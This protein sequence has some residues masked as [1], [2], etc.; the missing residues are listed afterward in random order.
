MTTIGKLNVKH[1]F[2]VNPKLRNSMVLA[3]D[4]ILAYVCGHQTVVMNT[5]SREQS[6]IPGATQP[7]VSLG[8][9][10]LAASIS[11]KFIAVADKAEP[12]AAVT[13]YDSQTLRRKKVLH[14]NELGSREIKCVAFSEDGKLCLTQGA[15]PEWNLVLWNVEKTPKVMGSVKISMS[16]ETPVHQVS[17]C[18]WDPSVIVVFGKSIARLFRYTDGQLRPAS[19]SLRRDHANFISHMWLGEDKLIIGTEMGEILLV[20][21]LEFRAVVYPTGAESEEVTPIL[22]FAPTSRGFVCGTTGGEIRYFDRQDDV[23]EHYQMVEPSFHLPRDKERGALHHPIDKGNIIALAMGADDA[24]I[25]QTDSQQIYQFA[26]NHGGAGGKENSFSFLVSSFHGP[27]AKGESAITGIDCALWRPIAATCGKDCTVRVWNLADRKIEIMKEFEDEPTALSVHP[28]GLYIVVGFTERIR[29]LAVLLDDLHTCKDFPVRHCTYVKFARGGQYFAAVSGSNIYL[30]NTYTGAQIGIMR[31]H[32]GRPR[33]LIFSNYDSKLLSIGAEGNVFVWDVMACTRRPEQYAGITPFQAGAALLDGSKAFAATS[34]RIIREV[35]FQKAAAT[36]P[37]AAAAEAKSD[38]AIPAGGGKDIHDLDVGRSVSHMILD[39]A[40]QVLMIGTGDED[41]PGGIVSVMTASQNNTVFDSVDLHAGPVTAL[42]ISNCGSLLISGDTH[43]TLVISEFEGVIARGTVKPREGTA[44]YELIEEV[45]I[46]RSE[47]ESR[48]AKLNELSMKVDELNQNNTHQLKK[49]EMEHEQKIED[50]TH[51]FTTQLNSEN[52]KYTGVLSDKQQVEVEYGSTMQSLYAKQESE[53]NAVNTKYKAK[54]NNEASRHK[55]LVGETDEMHKR[56]SEENRALVESHQGYLQQ[57]TEEY[58]SKSRVEHDMQKS[59]HAEKDSMQVDFEVQRGDVDFDADSEIDTM[60]A[61]YESRLAMEESLGIELMANHAIMKKNLQMLNKDAD[62]QKEEI[63]RLK[64]K[65]TRL[66]ETIRS[67][68]KDIQSH[69]KEIR[70]REETITDKEKRIFDLKKKNQ[71]LEKFRFVLDYKI[72]ELKLQIAPREN[73]I[74]TMRKQIEEMDLELDQYH[75]SNQSL[76]LM[77]GELKLKL[78]GLRRELETQEDRVAANGLVLDKLKRD[79]QEAWECRDNY[80][81]LK[82]KIVTLYRIY[83]QESS[84]GESTKKVGAEDPQEM[85]SRDRE[86]MERNLDALRRG[87]KTDSLAHRRDLSKMMRENVMLTKELNAL[88]KDGRAMELQKKA[89][90]NTPLGPKTDLTMIMDLLHIKAKNPTSTA[91]GKSSSAKSSSAAPNS[92][93]D[94]G[95]QTAILPTAPES[96]S[97]PKSRSVALRTTS[98][99]G[100]ID[101]AS[102]GSRSRNDQWEA[103]RE[104]QMQNDNMSQLETHIRALCNHLSIDP[105]TMLDEIDASLRTTL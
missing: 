16:D 13:F 72:K 73:D 50:I 40:R 4:H 99:S 52:D 69:K 71:E 88:R 102:Q 67:L 28:A 74:A 54:L 26:Q 41:R 97:G 83:V 61:K 10:T 82:P 75:K 48:K 38:S 30:F 62:Q 36:A 78:D 43:G 59:L 7:Y 87:L 56:W 32:T 68:E 45:L 63:R 95:T 24:L 29:L 100:K 105:Q 65:E 93:G 33:S 84:G 96:R 90:E 77:I 8:I 66:L 35:T 5:E 92:A 53:L 12:V 60:K 1:A 46:H 104:I 23:K 58:E 44:S 85:Y 37:D 15:G 6:F 89:V 11:K 79:I 18:P 76:N 31:G 64:D 51:K 21:N 57:L 81:I 101:P 17:F 55:Q 70:E 9:T 42:C 47:L 14:Y 103:W 25:C 98:A 39:D 86:Q 91:G 22:C 80:G 94:L 27:N 34:D 3:D 20:D 19:L 49:K 2:G